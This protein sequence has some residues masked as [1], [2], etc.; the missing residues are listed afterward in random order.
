[1][2]VVELGCGLGVPSLVAARQGAAVLATDVSME[3]LELVERNAR[4]NGL[5]LSTARVDWESAEEL[6]ARGPFD[7]ALAADVLYERGSV[8]PLLELLSRLAADVWLADPG[9]PAAEPFL[10]QAHRRWSVTTTVRDH[11]GIHRLAEPSSG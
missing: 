11:I 1:M 3:A 5:D 4:E 2:R 9:R 8:A 6:T 10:E 7:L